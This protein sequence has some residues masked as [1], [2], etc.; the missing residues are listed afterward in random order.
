MTIDEGQSVLTGELMVHL[1]GHLPLHHND[2][3]QHLLY[4]HAC[5]SLATCYPN[6]WTRPRD[7][8]TLEA[9]TLSQTKWSNSLF[10]SA[11][12]GFWLL[13]ANS[14]TYIYQSQ[15]GNLRHANLDPLVTQS[16]LKV[17]F[18]KI[19][20]NQYMVVEANTHWKHVS[21]PC[22]TEASVWKWIT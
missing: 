11:N 19:T 2:Q 20:K 1:K 7:T 6:L 15:R 5:H 21:V 18:I 8:W 12:N 10:S 3:V 16:C 13:G 4:C 22:Q 17:L 14:T 9:D